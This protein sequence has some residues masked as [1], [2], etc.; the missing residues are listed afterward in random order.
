MNNY[1]FYSNLQKYQENDIEHGIG[2]KISGAINSGYNWVKS[3]VTGQSDFQPTYYQKIDNAYGPGKARYF[4]SKEE[5][6]AYQRELRGY[7][8]KAKEDVK[9]RNAQMSRNQGADI[10]AKQRAAQ[11]KYNREI[12]QNVRSAQSGREAAMRNSLNQQQAQKNLDNARVRE[13]QQGRDAA[14]KNSNK[15]LTK[16]TWDDDP[17]SRV[18]KAYEQSEAGRREAEAERRRQEQIDKDKAFTRQLQEQR[19]KERQEKEEAARNADRQSRYNAEKSSQNAYRAEKAIKRDEIIQKV[20]NDVK[21]EPTQ[22]TTSI[23][24]YAKKYDMDPEDL[25]IGLY[26]TTGWLLPSDTLSY[27]TSEKTE[28]KKRKG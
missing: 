2:S 23:E 19:Y 24:D 7:N 4:Y 17:E 5:W 8:E 1:E 6:D 14:I 18:R 10:A 28:I 21:N 3:K 16:K 20:I 9:L 12:S 26:N 27:G 25:A 11:E 13:A 22:F 15:N